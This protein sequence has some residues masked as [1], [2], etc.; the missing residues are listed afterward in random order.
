[1]FNFFVHFL[2]GSTANWLCDFFPPI[3]VNVKQTNLRSY[4]GQIFL[5][6]IFGYCR[7]LFNFCLKICFSLFKVHMQTFS[8]TISC[9]TIMCQ[10]LKLEIDKEKTMNKC[11]TT[12]FSTFTGNLYS[13]ESLYWEREWDI[14]YFR[15]F[16]RSSYTVINQQKK[17]QIVYIFS[18]TRIWNLTIFAIFY[19]VQL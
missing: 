4:F 2:T 13:N 7:F 12:E 15:W 17:E 3:L 5:Y 14:F 10:Q 18:S 11:V 16:D 8:D 1:M 9:C 19:V 6:Y